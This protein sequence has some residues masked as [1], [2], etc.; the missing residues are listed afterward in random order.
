LKEGV[1]KEAIR[2]AVAKGLQKAFGMDA[3][4]AKDAD[5]SLAKAL[6]VIKEMKTAPC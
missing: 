3:G 2:R 4:G 6:A 1:S 5:R